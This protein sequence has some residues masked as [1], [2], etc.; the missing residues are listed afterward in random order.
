MDRRRLVRPCFQARCGGPRASGFLGTSLEGEDHF[1]GV[2][3][4][5]AASLEK[6]PPRI[7]VADGDVAFAFVRKYGEDLFPETPVVYCGMPRPAPEL[8]AQCDNC[9]GVFLPDTVARTV[10]FLF[11]LRPETSLVVGVTDGLPERAAARATAESVVE[12]HPSAGILF[13]GHEPGDD[14]GLDLELL[15]S[16]ASSVPSGGAV[17]LLGFEMDNTGQG[18]SMDDVLQIFG[19][20][21]EAPVFVTEGQW[22]REGVLGGVGVAPVAHGRLVGDFVARILAGERA[23]AM[24]PVPDAGQ[25][26]V[27]LTVLARFGLSAEHLPQETVA[28]NPPPKPDVAAVGVVPNTAFLVAAGGLVAV[29]ILGIGVAV[30]RRKRS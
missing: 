11:S 24:A 14:G 16:V 18:V 4:R 29:C 26:I 22:V 15:R 20:R 8:L 25:P 19:S 3:E 21:S 10:D 9:T 28:L 30:R 1:D 2:A 7:V 27:D 17:L 23:E 13:P 12:R 6:T 5:L